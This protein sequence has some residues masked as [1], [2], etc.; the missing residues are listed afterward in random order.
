M[1]LPAPRPARKQLENSDVWGSTSVVVAVA[2]NVPLDAGIWM[3]Y[4]PFLSPVTVLSSC[5]PSPNPEGSQAELR[6]I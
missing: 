1:G 6:K 4:L 5:S 3:R 2:V